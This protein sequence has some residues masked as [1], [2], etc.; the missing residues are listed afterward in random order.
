MLHTGDYAVGLF[1][2]AD[3]L[4]AALSYHIL[5]VLLS[6]RRVLIKVA[7][8]I[9]RIIICRMQPRGSG[10]DWTGVYLR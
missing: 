7:T 10:V 6:E 1:I 9:M 5:S 8:K 2:D 3:M 4:F